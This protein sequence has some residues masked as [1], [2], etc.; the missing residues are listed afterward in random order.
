MAIR[1]IVR[2]IEPAKDDRSWYGGLYRI[3]YCSPEGVEYARDVHKSEYDRLMFEQEL[4]DRPITVEDLEKYK[5]LLE[6]EH[7]DE[8]ALNGE[9]N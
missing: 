3:W 7:R 2:V 8:E 1:K 5:D 6:E 9:C 4:L